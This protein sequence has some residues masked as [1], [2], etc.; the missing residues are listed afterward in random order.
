MRSDLFQRR[1]SIHVKLTKEVHTALREKLFRHGITMQD[2]FQDCAE[3]ILMDDRR[4]AMMISRIVEKKLKAE[5]TRSRTVEPMGDMDSET[6]Y[7]LLER[8]A[9]KTS[10]ATDQEDEFQS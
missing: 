3:A 2:V 5:L 9:N 6:L 8:D 7:N 1:K 4:S 10:D